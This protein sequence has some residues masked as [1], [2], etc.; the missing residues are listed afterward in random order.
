M[1]AAA[2][3]GGDGTAASPLSTIAAAVAQASAGTSIVVHPGSYPGDIYVSD[4]S[5]TAAAPIWI[6]G[7]PG[8]ARPV[9]DG[10]GEGLHLSKV[11]Y[12]VV[13]DLEVQNATGNGINCDDGGDMANVDATR[14][15][16]FDN[17]FIHDIGTGGNEDC[18]KLSGL[19]DYFVLNGHFA[20]CGGSG[21]G[22]GIDH[23]GCHSGRDREQPVRGQQR[24]RD[25]GEGRKRRHPHLAEPRE[26]RRRARI[27]HGRLDRHAVL[28][29]A[30]CRPPA[31]TS[32]RRTSAPKPT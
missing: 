9:L 18:L 1:D 24:Q 20:R 2:S 6:G 23:V 30:R 22:S 13:H 15:V 10:G 14:F 8:Q 19:D 12:L 3:S 4:L 17:L 32:R 31:T 21:S 5:G 7:I 26:E 11:R 25:P 16:L 27:Q 28:P 29:A